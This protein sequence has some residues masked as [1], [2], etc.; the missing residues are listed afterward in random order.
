[1]SSKLGGHCA[2]AAVALGIPMGFQHNLASASPS[3]YPTV[4]EANVTW[5][6]CFRH[7]A[8]LKLEPLVNVFF[9]VQR[10]T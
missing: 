10:D 7:G 9:S 3:K 5:P 4:M 8:R 1:M 6:N 2:A